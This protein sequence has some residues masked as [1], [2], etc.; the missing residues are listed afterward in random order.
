[1]TFCV[2]RF[3]LALLVIIFAWWHV[4]WAPVAL[5]IVGALLAI[6]ALKI[7]FCCLAKK[8]AKKETPE[9]AQ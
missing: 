2:C 5:T 7:D 3:V 1:M 4:S 6:L 8:P 9:V